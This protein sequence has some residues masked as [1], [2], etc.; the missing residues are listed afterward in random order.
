MNV[1]EKPI[2][3]GILFK[4]ENMISV[5]LYDPCIRIGEDVDF[6]LR[7]DKSYKIER[8]NLPLYRYRMHKKN[9]T[10]NE[11]MNNKYMKKIAKKYSCKIDNSYLP[12]EFVHCNKM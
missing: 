4:K 7:F 10:I 2:A 8:I 11:N 3:C 12:A 5:G 6:R 1:T 9:L